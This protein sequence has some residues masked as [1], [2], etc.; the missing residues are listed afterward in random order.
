MNL[1]NVSDKALLESTSNLAKNEREL[2]LKVLH[3][4]REV[5]RRSLFATLSYSSLFEYAVVELKYSASAAQR[6]ISSM[7]LL[8]VLPEIEQKVQSGSLSL[9]TLSQAQSFFRQ[10]KTNA[11]QKRSILSSLENKSAREVEKELLLRSS[12]PTR[13]I[14][15]RLR[16]ISTTHTEVKFLLEEEL[17]K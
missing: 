13:F 8:K 5:E 7:R 12:E 6:R 10:E 9:S 17:L 14:K 11:T 4:L 2:T 16:P 3:H 15:E 1:R